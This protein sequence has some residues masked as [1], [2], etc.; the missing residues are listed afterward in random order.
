M[1]KTTFRKIIKSWMKNFSFRFKTIRLDS[2]AEKK[3]D[4][5]IIKFIKQR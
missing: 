4:K 3:S 5:L 1:A 2:E